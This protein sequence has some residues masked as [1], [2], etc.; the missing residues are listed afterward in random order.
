[1]RRNKF[2]FS[3][4]ELLVS[5]AIIGILVGLLLPAV[6]SAREAARRT[7]CANNLKNIGLALLNYHD[8]TKSFP[9][10]STHYLSPWNSKTTQI[11]W[12]AFLLPQLEQENLFHQLDF[13]KPYNHSSNLTA[14][15]KA[16]PTFVCP[17]GTR[18]QELSQGLGPTDYGGIY[19]QRITQRNDPPN[20]TMLIGKTVS[21]RQIKDGTS[22]TIVIGESTDWPDGQWINGRNLFDQA[23]AI[24]KAP[25][26]ENDLSSKH[27][28]LAGSCFAD[29]HVDFL[30]NAIDKKI[31][32]A[33]CTRAGGEIIPAAN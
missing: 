5:I 11:A 18:G 19:G 22:N 3:L 15:S 23:F 24:G 20:G 10:G 33:L 1:M 14:A 29:G 9:P 30:S 13:T 21:I 2:G 31:L 26:F 7:L 27:P 4:V 12:N 8:S 16:I 25:P 32:A 17:S 28:G 6:Q